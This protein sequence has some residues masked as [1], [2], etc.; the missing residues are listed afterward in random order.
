MSERVIYNNKRELYGYDLISKYEAGIVLDGWE[1]K[2]VKNGNANF[3]GSYIVN[4]NG[5]LFL[6]QAKILPYKHAP[7]PAQNRQERDKKVLLNKYEINRIIDNIKRSGIT[8]LVS[9]VYIKNNLVKLE[10]A[11]VKG[12]KKY[13]KRQKL[14]DRDM[15]RSLELDL[16]GR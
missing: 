8:V 15:R 2:S 3:S 14:K 11:V 6:R 7:T 4:N 5:E 13:Q 16:K 12:K 9:K 1:V 10:I